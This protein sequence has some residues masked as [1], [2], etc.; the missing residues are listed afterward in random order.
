MSVKPIPEGFHTVT[1]Y[2][3]V[4][5][6]P[7]LIDFLSNT[8]DAELASDL[9]APDGSIYHAAVKIGNSMV[10]MGDSNE[11]Y[12]PMPTSLYL[13]VENA[14]AVYQQ[15]LQAGAE[16]IQEPKNQFYGDRTAFV[17]DAFGNIWGIATQIEELS[18]EEINRRLK[19]K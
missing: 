19:E 2:L 12:P 15:A 16:S 6:V 14:D 17:K 4:D 3:I 1:P 13:Y 18:P 5:G 10:M 11:G 7:E 8:F 9:K